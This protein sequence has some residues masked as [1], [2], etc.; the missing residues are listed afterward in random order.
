MYVADVTAGASGAD[1]LSLNSGR[2]AAGAAAYA[3]LTHGDSQEDSSLQ[4]AQESATSEDVS[5]PVPPMLLLHT[6][7]S[8]GKLI[9][10]KGW[11]RANKYFGR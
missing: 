8:S 11:P 5:L 6:E 10:A 7:A 9:T 4:V 3:Y 2:N 1:L